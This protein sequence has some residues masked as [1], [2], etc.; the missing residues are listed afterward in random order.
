MQ[1]A[2]LLSLTVCLALVQMGCL[3]NVGGTKVVKASES[4]KAVSF[5]SDAGMSAFASHVKSSYPAEKNL[6]SGYFGIPFIISVHE[7][8][9]LSENAHFN[10][11]IDK[12]DL[13]QNQVITDGELNAAGI[14]VKEK[15][16]ADDSAGSSGF[17][18]L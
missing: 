3:I 7:Q 4:R 8:R 5:E 6:G 12:V 17:Q 1:R 15:E 9:V 2:I 13:D 18:T 16:P 10:A 14:I 11:A